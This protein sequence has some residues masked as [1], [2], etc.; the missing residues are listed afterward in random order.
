[1][2]TILL[3]TVATIFNIS[4]QQFSAKTQKVHSTALTVHD[5]LFYL[6]GMLQISQ[7]ASDFL[8]VFRPPRILL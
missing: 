3:M 5:S 1:M 8:F 6:K 2:I 4:D 7:L